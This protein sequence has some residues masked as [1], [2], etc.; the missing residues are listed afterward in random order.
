MFRKL[1]LIAAIALTPFASLSQTVDQPAAAPADDQAKATLELLRQTHTEVNGLRLPENRISFASELASLMWDQDEREAR[2]IY[3]GVADDFRQLLGQV[4]AQMN[5][6]P[7]P[8]DDQGVVTW[9]EMG[10]MTEPSDW[11]R[12]IKKAAAAISVR[13]SI[14]MNIAEHD[15]E[16]AL[17]F[18]YQTQAISNPDFK[19][20]MAVGDNTLEQKLIDQVALADPAKA[21][22]LA[23]R[24]LDK[25][26]NAQ[27]VDLLRKL[28][29]KDPDKGADLAASYLAKIKSEA[30]ETLDL[31][32]TDSLLKYGAQ[33]LDQSR[34]VNGPR[35]ILTDSDLR[36]LADT[37]S[38]AV[39]A[40]S[41][42]SNTPWATY[43]KDVERFQP[44]R[45][46]QI[47][48]RIPTRPGANRAAAPPPAY[49]GP[50]NSQSNVFTV[51]GSTNMAQIQARMQ[52]E[53]NEKKMM[54]DIAKVGTNKVNADQR[55]TIITQARRTLMST[56]GRDKKVTGLSLLAAQ[57][58]KSGDKDLADEIMRDASSFV[59]PQ[60]KNYQDFLLSWMLA[61]GYAAVDPDRAFSLLDD[62]IGR[63]NEV[64][65]SAIR[66]AEFVDTN[67]DIVVDGEFQVG[68]FAGGPGGGIVR[69]LTSAL[70]GFDG[71]IKQ[72]AK[73]DFDRTR[74]LTDRFERPE[75]RVLA[76]M[77]VLKALLGSKKANPTNA[78]VL[79]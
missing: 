67:E 60:P 58:L 30:P 51:S 62:T 20:L 18:F 28:Y 27:Q 32:A 25:G 76:K 2:T 15:P 39:L 40:R 35:A 14:V 70:T 52:R 17:D 77:I 31:N 23:K 16:M 4:D 6:T 38:Q 13:Q 42:T 21:A 57:V 36:D 33:L 11:Q 69:G 56:P 34:T 47:R 64:L 7:K 43:A 48:A 46:V 61:S 26:F 72:L 24:S 3:A 37:L 19:K 66:V 71:T 73:A 5:S 79:K 45:A 1:L 54:D 74:A 68:G 8:S 59:N 44:G 78:P 65:A 22:Q 50:A 9:I 12:A 49:R 29:T 41:A 53:A 10:G 63:T 75:A 55:A